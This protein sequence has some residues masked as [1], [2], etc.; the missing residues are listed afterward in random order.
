L[1]R[2]EADREDVCRNLDVGRWMA[3]NALEVVEM[4]GA[5]GAES[6]AF[7]FCFGRASA[8]SGL[9]HRSAPS[10]EI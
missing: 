10:I 6:G 4:G 2:R 8:R 3:V 9:A 7:R 5:R 1:R